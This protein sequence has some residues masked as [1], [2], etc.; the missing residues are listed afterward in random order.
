MPDTSV[1]DQS[2]T[3]RPSSGGR[4]RGWPAAGL[5][6]S[7]FVTG[8][9]GTTLP[10]PL[11]PT[12]AAQ[13]GFGELVTTLVFATYAAGVIVALLL[14]G[15]WSDQLGRRP[16]L[17]AGLGLSALSAAAFLMPTS[18]PWLFVGRVLSG[19]SAGI[20]TGTATATVVDLV[21]ERRR[22]RASLLA[23][24]VNMAGLGAGPVLSGVL[25]QYAPHPTRLVFVVDLGLVALGILAVLVVSEPVARAA[26]PQLAPRPPKVPVEVRPTFVRAAIS[27][28][29]GFSVIGLF[30]AL[31]P[32][33]LGDV[34]HHH[35]PALVG[36]VVA[37][38]FAG[39]ILGQLL[40]TPLGLDRALSAGC[41]LLIVGA[42]LIAV[43]L[44]TRSLTLLVAGAAVGGLG[45]G[46]SFRAGLGS[47]AAATP[48]RLRGSVTSTY[49]VTLYVGISLP[50]IGEAGL[51]SAVG[52]VTA[53]I[54]FTVVVAL[55]AAVA[56]VLLVVGAA[57][58]GRTEP[59]P[60]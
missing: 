8:M 14:V 25:A 11:Y 22:G 20:L 60:G 28:V 50:V 38:V 36:V 13:L 23:A 45:Q 48:E 47:L 41:G 57:R 12:Y 40:S 26:R 32:S 51:A 33:F 52:L 2:E 54:V 9:L 27:G 59:S 3:D 46:T 34:L 6:A 49:F 35:S 1:V 53:G 42:A 19:F 16:M 7:A 10:T 58:S 24:S 55:L 15:H 18:L 37:V 5:V 17:L 30:T 39:S 56:V 4:F 31:S 29:A 43:S 21:P 44:P